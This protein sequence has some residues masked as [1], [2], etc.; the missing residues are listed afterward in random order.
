MRQEEGSRLQAIIAQT[1]HTLAARGHCCQTA[2]GL[3][4]VECLH[5]HKQ[6]HFAFTQT[7]ISDM[8]SSHQVAFSTCCHCHKYLQLPAK[9]AGSWKIYGSRQLHGEC[10]PDLACP[11]L[12]KGRCQKLHPKHRVARTPNQPNLRALEA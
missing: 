9:T 2:A 4:R 8:H 3:E 5:N 6:H 7:L 10:Q 1:P 12:L 11:F